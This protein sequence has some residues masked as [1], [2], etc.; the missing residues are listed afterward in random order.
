MVVLV[1]F[2]FVLSMTIIE[3]C[4]GDFVDTCCPFVFMPLNFTLLYMSRIK[5]LYDW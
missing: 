1:V 3:S 5:N 2:W 4:I